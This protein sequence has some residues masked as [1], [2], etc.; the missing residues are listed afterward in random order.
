[1]LW[2]IEAVGFGW[3]AAILGLAEVG[4]LVTVGLQYHH[5]ICHAPVKK[6]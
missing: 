5:E 2:R 4:V 6:E 3:I 1:M